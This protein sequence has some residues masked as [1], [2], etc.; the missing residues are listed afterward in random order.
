MLTTAVMA[1][2]AG[3]L[4]TLETPVAEVRSTAAGMAATLEILVTAVRTSETSWSKAA[5][6]TTGSSW[7]ATTG[8]PE[9]LEKPGNL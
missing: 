1:A 3:A 7:K 8:R 6:E 9:Q 4:E 2:I 5:Q